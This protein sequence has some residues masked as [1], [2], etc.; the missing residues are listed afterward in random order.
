MKLNEK[1]KIELREKIE[2]L[3]LGAPDGQ[4]IHLDK[5]LLEGLLFDT[6]EPKSKDGVLA[7]LPVWSGNF[8]RKID[9]SEVSFDGVAWSVLNQTSG[10]NY[11]MPWTSIGDNYG[12]HSDETEMRDWKYRIIADGQKINY[13]YTNANID[14]S[15]SWEAK[16][17]GKSSFY[18]C[19][20]SGIDLSNKDL[21]DVEVIMDCNL[22]NTGV[23]LSSE[24]LYQRYEIGE[25]KK[26]LR[27]YRTSFSGNDLSNIEIAVDYS[28]LRH[29]IDLSGTGAHI[30]YDVDSMASDKSIFWHEN[31]DLAMKKAH[32]STAINKT[33]N[34]GFWDGCYVNGNLYFSD[35]DK[36]GVY[37]R[38]S[39]G[40][41]DSV[42][43]N[44]EE[45]I[46]NMK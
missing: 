42:V 23:K 14:F 15:S 21:S 28:Y 19:D 16:V 13:S 20:F 40:I 18:L 37:A 35:A 33:T 29:D 8:L 9:L 3:L 11:N 45:Q 36:K 34:E 26:P 12:L 2:E 32:I 41:F 24:Q 4:R 6:I 46:G 38:Y 31:E 7:K 10:P 17:L 25:V 1:S 30:K 44:I 22:S 27:I 39:Q 5:D 43:G